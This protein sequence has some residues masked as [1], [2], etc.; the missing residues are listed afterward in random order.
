MRSTGLGSGAGFAHDQRLLP[1]QVTLCLRCAKD[2]Q[3]K[4]RIARVG[5]SHLRRVGPPSSPPFSSPGM[6][7]RALLANSLRRDCFDL[8][9][10]HCQQGKQHA[11]VT[12]DPFSIQDEL[13]LQKPP[14]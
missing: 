5:F 14:S 8:H 1:V 6:H 4:L 3:V 12:H 9:V 2:R 11:K 13:Q 7:L 10:A